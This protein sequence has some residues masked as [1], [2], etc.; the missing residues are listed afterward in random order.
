[1]GE[2]TAVAPG[3]RITVTVP[4]TS[5]NLGPGFDALGL[6][7]GLFDT[8]EVE[9]TDEP[10]TV[11]EVSGEGEDVL[12]RDETHLVARILR[13]RWAALGAEPSGLR[14]RAVNRIPHGRGLGS[15]AAAVVSGLL[16]ADALLPEPLRAR[17]GGLAGVFAEATRIEGHPDNVAPAL[18][19]GLVL[20]Y[21]PGGGP[22]RAVD[23]DLAAGI[24]PV[25]AVPDVELSTHRARSLLPASVP[26]SH[27]AANSARVGLLV[28]ALGGRPSL[29]L[30]ATEDYL[31]Q[32]FRAEA[33]PDSARLIAALR[34]EGAAAVVSG[35]GPTV[36]AFA[37]G[38]GDAERIGGLIAAATAGSAVRWRVLMP[39][40]DRDGAKVEV[41]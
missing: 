26:H 18:H 12:P 32:G 4:A 10:R 40:V 22:A 23:L 29:L 28:A 39:G 37:D 3:Q 31:H 41:H 27:A 1:M 16:A 30:D 11:V 14:L 8:L 19:G 9:T 34:A 17:A 7:V 36:L 35:A 6:A 24:V 15:S 21:E 38:P 2:Q 33:M 13:G 20:S 5:A 25:V